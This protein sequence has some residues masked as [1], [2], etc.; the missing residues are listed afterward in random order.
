M[1]GRLFWLDDGNF[2]SSA[3]NWGRCFLELGAMQCVGGV[4]AI[5]CALDDVG[6]PFV[7]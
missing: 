5:L 1:F 7:Y 6:W 2:V 4:P 3:K